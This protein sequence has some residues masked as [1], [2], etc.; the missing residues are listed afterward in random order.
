MDIHELLLNCFSVAVDRARPE[1]CIE[2]FVPE[3]VTR[4]RMIVVGAG[5]ASAAMA[6]A[7]EEHYEGPLE[8]MVITRYGHS[9][10]TRDIR[11]LE[12][13]HPIPD[14]QGRKAVKELLAYLETAGP[15][16]TIMCLIS[17]GGS[18]LLSCPVEGISFAELQDIQTQLLGCG[19]SIDEVNTVRKHLNVALGGGLAQAAPKSKMITLAISDVVGDDPSVIASGASVADPSTLEDASNILTRYGIDVPQAALDA[20]GNPDFETPKPGDALFEKHEYHL[21][22]AP[23]CSLEAA[24]DFWE[25]HGFETQ[26]WD[27]ELTGDSEEAAER[28][29]T[30]ILDR[31]ENARLPCAILS[32]GETTMTLRKG[33]GK[34]GPNTHLMLRSAIMLD[35]HKQIYA[36]SCDTDGIDGAGDHAGA[37]IT[38]DTL[39]KS[40][41]KGL[42]PQ[43]FIDRQDSYA[44]FDAIGGLVKTGP[45]HTNVNDFRVF[46]VLEQN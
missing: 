36:M 41:D 33:H 25:D 12:A 7:F 16:D 29:V 43:E 31:L 21:I 20:L 34:G 40:A 6:A 11:V 26:I 9:V 23:I 14:E 15:D 19:A 22:A 1:Q 46:L 24:K 38:P 5:K 35:G 10:P 30:Y 32:G 27:A 18:S 4:G 17:G 37:I 28:H 8:G 39:K 2:G 42:T 3:A 44:L 45:T 13:A